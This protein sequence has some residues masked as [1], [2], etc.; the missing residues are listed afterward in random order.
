MNVF[1]VTAE[2]WHI[3]G[4]HCHVHATREG[5]DQR[6]VEL[7]AMLVEDADREL[8]P[9]LPTDVTVENREQCVEMLQEA[10]GAAHTYVCVE[11]KE[12]GP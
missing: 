2:H 7:T 5:A 10:Y 1:I 12:V 9:D 11:E 4:M 8:C 3:S 6:A